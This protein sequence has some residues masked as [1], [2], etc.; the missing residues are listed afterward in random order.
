MVRFGV[1]AGL[2]NHEDLLKTVLE[3]ERLGFDSAW[4]WDHLVNPLGSVYW[5]EHDRAPLS[6]LTPPNL[7]CWTRAKVRSR[8]TG[9]ESFL[10]LTRDSSSLDFIMDLTKL[11]YCKFLL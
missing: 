6:A 3:I 7:E 10:V 4:I 9:R 11:F 8:C 1:S 2:S 5:K